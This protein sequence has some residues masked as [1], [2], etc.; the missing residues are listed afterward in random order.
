MRIAAQPA[1]GASA[2]LV[3]TSLSYA[4]FVGLG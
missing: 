1:L 2:T 3:P 4:N